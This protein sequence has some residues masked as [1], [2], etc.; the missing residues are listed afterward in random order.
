M[1]EAAAIDKAQCEKD[2]ALWT[3]EIAAWKNDHARA[4]NTLQQVTSF[5]LKH[6]AQLDDHLKE[7]K[8]HEGMSS[9]NPEEM[10]TIRE[11]HLAVKHR[12]NA[13]RGRHRGL[14]EEILQLQVTLHKAGH[15]NI[16]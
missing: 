9:T 12:H 14:I 2:H 8:E 7:V 6:E 15:G 13:L 5:I 10:Q 4:L 1:P 16:L 11:R 3:E